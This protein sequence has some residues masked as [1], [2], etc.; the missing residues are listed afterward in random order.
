VAD[1][2]H[3]RYV[4]RWLHDNKLSLRFDF[5]ICGEFGLEEAFLLPPRIPGGLDGY[6]VVGF[7]LRV[8]E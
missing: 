4:W 6:R 2:E 1:V 8:F 5:A 3:A 7:I